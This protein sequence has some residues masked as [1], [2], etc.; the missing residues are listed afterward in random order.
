MSVILDAP[1]VR[2]AEQDGDPWGHIERDDDEEDWNG[3]LI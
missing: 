1:W 2:K 3:E